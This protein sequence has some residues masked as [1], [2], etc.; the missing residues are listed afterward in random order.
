[1]GPATGD[2]DSDE[3]IDPAD[4]L[5]DG[6]LSVDFDPLGVSTRSF[7]IM[8]PAKPLGRATRGG[9]AADAV[10]L[11]HLP[12]GPV[13]LAA[14]IDPS[15]LGG[16]EALEELRPMAPSAPAMPEWIMANRQLIR[17]VE[18]AIYPS[19]L[20]VAGG[21]LPIMAQSV[22]PPTRPQQDRAPVGLMVY[23]PVEGRTFAPKR[24]EDLETI[25]ET[26]SGKGAEG[27]I[28]LVAFR[29]AGSR[30]NA[31]RALGFLHRGPNYLCDRWTTTT[32]LSM[33]FRYCY[34]MGQNRP[35]GACLVWLHTW[36]RPKAPKKPRWLPH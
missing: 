31:D 27:G 20:G 1:S 15:G 33:A 10:G 16:V 11:S 3:P 9:P 24:V 26:L 29:G 6:V 19:K 18:F 30:Q 17:R 13:V 25:R 34:A 4:G 14:S 28:T 7:A 8:D 23:A 22:F 5:L 36:T 35:S 12:K 32:S 21:G 2:S